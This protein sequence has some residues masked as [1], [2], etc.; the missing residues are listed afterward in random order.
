MVRVKLGAPKHEG[1]YEIELYEIALRDGIP[2]SEIFTKTLV[3]NL[4]VQV[5]H[6]GADLKLAALKLYSQKLGKDLVPESVMLRSPN[7]DIG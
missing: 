4:D 7:Y 6:S 1:V 3:G 2:D 5:G